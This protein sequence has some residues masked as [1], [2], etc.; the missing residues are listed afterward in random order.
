MGLILKMNVLLMMLVGSFLFIA[1]AM[2]QITYQLT[3]Y[4]SILN[5]S[6]SEKFNK[7]YYNI[8][9]KIERNQTKKKRRRS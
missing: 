8:L 6:D 5:Q 1:V 7:D 9:Q 4:S 2:P 3:D